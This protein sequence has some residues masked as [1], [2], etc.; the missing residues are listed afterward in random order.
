M[1][2]F[3]LSRR[4]ALAGAGVLGAAASIPFACAG[5]SPSRTRRIIGSGATPAVLQ[6]VAHQDDDFLFMNPDMA[7]TLDA[8][9]PVTTVYLTAGEA[10]GAVDGSQTRSQFAADRLR[11]H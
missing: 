6:I 10:G 3:T 7:V 9:I 11:Q 4:Q 8:G 5:G 1:R 2:R